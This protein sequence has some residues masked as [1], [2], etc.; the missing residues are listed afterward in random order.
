M[1]K[2]GAIVLSWGLI[3]ASM[4]MADTIIPGGNVSGNWTQSGSPYL[5]QGQITIPANQELVISP[6]VAV[7][8]QGH[9]KFI[10]SGKLNAVGASSD[11]I[12]FT[13]ANPVSG[14]HGLRFIT[15]TDS[16]LLELCVI[17]YGNATG[18]GQDLHGGGIYCYN[19][20]LSVSR[21]TIQGN[22]AG[23]WGGGVYMYQCSDNCLHDNLIQYNSAD[24]A[25][26]VN[27][28]YGGGQIENNLIQFNTA[29]SWSGGGI[30][31]DH[32]SPIVQENMIMSNSSAISAGTGLYIAWSSNPIV[33]YNLIAQNQYYGVF[34][35]ADCSPILTNNTIA[36]NGSGALEVLNDS[37]MTGENNIIWGNGLAYY[38]WSGCSIELTYSDIQGGEPGIGN[39]NADP[40]F[41]NPGGN[42]YYL[43]ANS[44]CVDAGNPASPLD[45][46]GTIAD[47]G[48]YC[49]D[50]SGGMGN[51]TLV[52]EPVNPPIIIPPGGGSFDYTAALSCDSSGYAFFDAWTNLVLPDGQI[53]G[54]LYVRPNL[55]LP[56]GGSLFR[57]LEMYASA[58]AMPGTYEFHGYL[59]DYPD[60]VWVEDSFTFVKQPVGGSQAEPGEAYIVLS[61]WDKTEL[62]Q[63]PASNGWQ[64][65]QSQDLRLGNSPE[66][67]NPET[68]FQISLPKDGNVQLLIY[69]LNGRLVGT[70]LDRSMEA[71]SY[72]EAWDA[73]NMPSGMYL[74]RL[75]TTNGTRTERC[76]LVK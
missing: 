30:N 69:D 22:S 47:M 73:A 36:D 76:L 65:V 8:F 23:D 18:S 29:T 33:K 38:I 54:P 52:L 72:E 27:W 28:Q 45:P 53:Y 13:A 26:G 11:S 14:W 9:F 57:Q 31:I 7:I 2:H 20:I 39:I 37:H 16:S 40:V 12:L 48:A 49:F 10:I 34:A 46:D 41:V 17:Q 58:L 1:Y 70:L 15:A 74:A 24:H 35:G 62:H 61:G 59:G 66:P 25:A 6:G 44:P 32:G 42:I 60:S 5:I 51:L 3:C 68:V 21:C 19:S 63:L 56:I 55:F 67:F 43:Q 75:V 64:T 50:Q 4:A 71:G